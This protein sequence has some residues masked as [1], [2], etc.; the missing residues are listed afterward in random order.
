MAQWQRVAE[1]RQFRRLK[2]TDEMMSTAGEESIGPANA[3]A[4]PLRLVLYQ[5]DIP[6]NTGTMMR[7]CACLGIGL[8]IVEPCGF[9]LDDKRLRR[10]AMDY[11]DHLDLHRVAS[12]EHYLDMPHDGRLI[13]LTTSGETCYT[14]FA[15]S[16]Q[17]RLLVGRESAG[18]P[19]EVLTTCAARLRIPVRPPM[20]SLNVALAAAMVAGEALRQIGCD[21]TLSAL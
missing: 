8:D 14:D 13:A 11:I 3:V 6:Q 1:A 5:P 2:L 12:W 17:D 18:L 19:E 10:A 7:L 9:V 16:P 15:F 20:R 4:P 21:E